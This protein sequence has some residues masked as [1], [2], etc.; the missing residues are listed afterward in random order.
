[1]GGTGALQRNRKITMNSESSRYYDALQGEVI[2]EI[3]ENILKPV[4]DP[5]FSFLI[6][7]AFFDPQI[8]GFAGV[9]FQKATLEKTELEH[10][11]TELSRN[12]CSHILITLITAEVKFLES[13]L[14]R[15]SGFIR[16]SVILRNSVLGFHLEG[17]FISNQPG[18]VGTHPAQFTRDPDWYLLERWQ[19]AARGMIRMMTV[20]PER[21]GAQ[22]FIRK[23]TQQGIWISL[24]HTQAEFSQLREAQTSGA[25]MITHLGNACPEELPRHDNIIHRCLALPDLLATLIPDGIHLPPVLFAQL[26]EL[27]G[28]TRLLFTSDAMSAAGAVPG[29][30]TLGNVETTVERDGAVRNP[31]GKGL[32]GSSLTPI[33]GFYT[34]I[35]LGDIGVRTAWRAWTRLRDL[36]FPGVVPPRLM[37]PFPDVRRP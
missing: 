26:V 8:N 14:Q 28:P 29:R 22:D 17:P 24:G 36:M 20:A 5:S 19:K 16:E 7:P 33:Q 3:P 32:T 23:A 10:A 18:T 31:N 30:Y 6:G 21:D 34:A 2:R 12:G 15:I 35:R 1:M 25:R 27:L 37:L 4:S 9:D 13:Q 11:I